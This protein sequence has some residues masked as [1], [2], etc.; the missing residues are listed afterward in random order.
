MVHRVSNGMRRVWRFEANTTKTRE[1]I[2]TIGKVVLV[3]RR[4][5]RTE[6]CPLESLSTRNR[7]DLAVPERHVD[8]H[9]TRLCL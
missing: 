7:W 1:G 2:G 4:A 6:L 3:G 5:A 9:S 8:S